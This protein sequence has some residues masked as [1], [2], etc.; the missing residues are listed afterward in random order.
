MSDSKEGHTTEENFQ[1]MFQFSNLVFESKVVF[2]PNLMYFLFVRVVP[3]TRVLSESIKI[4]A[5]L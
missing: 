1:V 3:N 5:V 2:K 4:A